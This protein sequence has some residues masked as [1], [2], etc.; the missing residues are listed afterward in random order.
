[1]D[2]ISEKTIDQLT[3]LTLSARVFE[4][5]VLLDVYRLI[6]LQE[7]TAQYVF[8]KH[9]DELIE[10]CLLGYLNVAEIDTLDNSDLPKY[11]MQVL[12]VLVNAFQTNSGQRIIREDA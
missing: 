8:T 11:H 3:D 10:V 7:S 9:W 6:V 1:M 5:T 12:K 2:L 4:K